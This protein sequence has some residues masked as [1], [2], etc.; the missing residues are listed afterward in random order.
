MVQSPRL[1]LIL[2]KRHTSTFSPI[3]VG[4]SKK[5]VPESTA[6]LFGQ[7]I[8]AMRQDGTLEAVF[9]RP[10]RAELAPAMVRY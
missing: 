2:N 8:A 3:V 6:A 5:R 4:V 9:A 1:R 10:M 7:T